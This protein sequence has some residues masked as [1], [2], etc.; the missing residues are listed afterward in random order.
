MELFNPHVNS[1]PDIHSGHYDGKINACKQ[2][3]GINCCGIL[4]EGGNLEP[5]Y[6]TNFD[7]QKIEYF[8]GLLKGQF[9]TERINPLTGNLI[10]K[11]RIKPNQGC[12]FF[13]QNEGKC[14]IFSYRPMDCRL[15]PLDIEFFN[16]T[17]YWAL[18]KY[19]CD[20]SQ[21]D[22]DHLLNYKDIALKILGDELHD[23]ATYPVPGMS[24]IGYELLMEVDR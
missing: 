11:M 9:A 2:C 24:K 21:T 19:G 15:F 17:Y 5:P 1:F 20:I 3:S 18:F 23:Y 7:I 4:E 6:L 8:T 16:E 13:D 14:E 12:I 22:L 10:Y